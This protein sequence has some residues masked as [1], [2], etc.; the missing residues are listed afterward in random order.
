MQIP[1]V[2]FTLFTFLLQRLLSPPCFLYSGTTGVPKGVVLTHGNIVADLA[3]AQ[4]LGVV[5]YPTD[6][7]LSYLPMA[8]MY[9]IPS[10]LPALQQVPFAQFGAIVAY[11]YVSICL[12]GTSGSVKPICG[13]Q[14]DALGF[15]RQYS[16]TVALFLL[17]PYKICNSCARSHHF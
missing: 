5:A 10:L 16:S 7:Y 3:G 1:A 15:I 9:S 4:A 6:V 17:P 14:A 13:V 11:T 12:V 2:S 8:H